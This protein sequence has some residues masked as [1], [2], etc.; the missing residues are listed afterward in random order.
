[1]GGVVFLLIVALVGFAMWR[2]R[3]ARALPDLPA[4]KDMAVVKQLQGSGA[5]LGEGVWVG[6][7]F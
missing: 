3:Q 5:F 2:R 7:H 1:M 4:L 6:V